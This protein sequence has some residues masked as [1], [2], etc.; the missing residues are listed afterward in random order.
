MGNS[1]ATQIEPIA[2]A[3][4]G[5]FA[6]AA[7]VAIVIAAARWFVRK[8]GDAASPSGLG[9]R[10]A[11]VVGYIFAGGLIVAGG[12]SISS[13]AKG[14]GGEGAIQDAATQ[15]GTATNPFAPTESTGLE[16]IA[17]KRSQEGEAISKLVDRMRAEADMQR[18]DQMK[19]EALQ[20]IKGS[21]SAAKG[22]DIV[23]IED[24]ETARSMLS[25]GD[26]LRY[27]SGVRFVAVTASDGSRFILPVD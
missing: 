18:R 17:G 27:T 14:A 7:L 8:G 5:V 26:Y 15:T 20:K 2:I 21:T 4:L 9:S 3:L 10:I 24:D 13:L 6:A 22:L 1:T 25:A 11:H 19:R 16:P 12:A 23:P